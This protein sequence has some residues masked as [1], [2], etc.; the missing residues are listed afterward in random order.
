MKRDFVPPTDPVLR[1]SAA[2]VDNFETSEL[3]VLI[4]DMFDTMRDAHGVGLAAPQIG[5]SARV[6]V[7]ENTKEIPEREI[8]VIPATILINP[9]I[10][11]SEGAVE[12]WEG[13][14]SIP[15]IRGWV[16][17]SSE[18]QYKAQDVD[19]HWIAGSASG[20][21]ARIIQHEID[22]LNGILFPDITGVTEPFERPVDV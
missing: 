11:S 1:A 2:V 10:T 5:V 19:G 8:F 17:R 21:H 13:C 14:L 6:I 7:F 3:R 4:S 22:H 16:T 20:M 12:D 15:G 18:I 9:V